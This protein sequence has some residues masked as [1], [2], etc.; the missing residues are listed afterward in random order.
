MKM[1]NPTTLKFHK[2]QKKVQSTPS[3]TFVKGISKASQSLQS[4]FSL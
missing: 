2:T 3:T 4:V 1:Y